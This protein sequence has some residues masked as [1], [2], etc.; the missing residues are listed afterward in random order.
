MKFSIS[1]FESGHEVKLNPS[2][3]VVQNAFATTDF[4]AG[5]AI[6]WDN[7][8]IP[9][10]GKVYKLHHV[11]ADRVALIP[12]GGDHGQDYFFFPFGAFVSGL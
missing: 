10:L 6:V 8:I 3:Q 12:P 11:L 2:A 7:A 5:E 4:S 9:M 1:A